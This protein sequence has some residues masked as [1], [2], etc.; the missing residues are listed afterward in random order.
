[1]GTE[2][3]KLASYDGDTLDGPEILPITETDEGATEGIT[4]SQ[5]ASGL[6]SITVDGSTTHPGTSGSPSVEIGDSGAGF[7]INSSG[8]IVAVDEAGNTTT[9]S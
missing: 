8:E 2:V 4:V 9:I 1:M 7:F 3:S 5:L 6:P